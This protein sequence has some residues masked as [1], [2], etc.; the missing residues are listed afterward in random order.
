[1]GSLKGFRLMAGMTQ[2]ELAEAIGTTQSHV[3][4]YERGVR[5][6]ESMPA[7]QFVRLFTVLDASPS[8]LLDD[9]KLPYPDLQDDLHDAQ[10]SEKED[11]CHIRQFLSGYPA[12]S[13]VA[14]T[15]FRSSTIGRCCGQLRSYLRQ[16]M[17][18]EARPCVWARLS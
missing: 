15:R 5:R 16:P 17:H 11:F 3:S 12:V 7:L 14:A 13:N 6:L 8:L 18:S 9:V 1:M 4:E 10:V 2:A